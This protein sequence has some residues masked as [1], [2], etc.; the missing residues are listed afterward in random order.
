MSR[1]IV[2]KKKAA[3]KQYIKGQLQNRYSTWY[4]VK[5]RGVKVSKEKS[6]LKDDWKTRMGLN[7]WKWEDETVDLSIRFWLCSTK[8][9]SSSD[10]NLWLIVNRIEIGLINLTLRGLSKS[11]SFISLSYFLTYWTGMSN[12]PFVCV[13]VCLRGCVC[14]CMCRVVCR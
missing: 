5:W 9:G 13:S 12:Q 1:R 11:N 8:I 10:V 7:M 6:S 14:N 2:T 3:Q 4:I